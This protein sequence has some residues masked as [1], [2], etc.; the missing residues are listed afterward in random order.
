MKKGDWNEYVITAKGNHLIHEINGKKMSEA[1]D[2]DPQKGAAEGILALQ[3]H[4]GPPMTVQFKDIRL[5]EL[6][7]EPKPKAD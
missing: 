2:E 5:K 3:I 7:E 1:I 4:M 6:K